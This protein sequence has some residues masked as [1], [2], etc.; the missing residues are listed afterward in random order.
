MGSR[1]QAEKATS[2]LKYLEHREAELV[3][4]LALLGERHAF[5]PDEVSQRQVEELS[6]KLTE[7]RGQIDATRADIPISRAQ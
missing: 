3:R 1:A 7:L 5:F 2:E 6:R 4:R